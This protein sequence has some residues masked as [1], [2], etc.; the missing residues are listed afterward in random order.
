MLSQTLEVIPETPNEEGTKTSTHHTQAVEILKSKYFHQGAG[1]AGLFLSCYM[2]KKIFKI[3]LIIILFY[4][5]GRLTKWKGIINCLG[6]S[7]HDFL[8]F[9]YATLQAETGHDLPLTFPRNLGFRRH[10]NFPSIFL[11]KPI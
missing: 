5:H 6:F 4:P 8:V 11:V 7:I 9:N 10:R 1:R 2:K 3:Y